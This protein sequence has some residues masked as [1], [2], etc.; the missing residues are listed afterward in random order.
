MPGFGGIATWPHTPVPPFLT[1]LNSLSGALAS[2][3]Y[4]FATSRYAGPTTIESTA[5]HARQLFFVAIASAAWP[6]T[7][8]AGVVP[9]VSVAA[10]TASNA[11]TGLRIE[12]IRGA[13]DI[14]MRFFTGSSRDL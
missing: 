12:R 4:F 13:R 8:Y 1:L 10:I 3:W 14:A 2:P 11:L 6:S 7:A 5:W 9:A